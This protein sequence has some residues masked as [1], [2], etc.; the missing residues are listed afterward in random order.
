[1]AGADLVF[2]LAVAFL[3]GVLAASSGWSLTLVGLGGFIILALFFYF[4]RAGWKPTL[5]VALIVWLVLLFGFFYYSVY[6]HWSAAE[7]RNL[8]LNQSVTVRGMIASEP[9]STEKVQLAP[10]ALAPPLAEIGRA[11]V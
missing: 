4:G 7:L 8:P 6:A 2:A 11:H 3:V 1:M 9:N 10:L 5:G